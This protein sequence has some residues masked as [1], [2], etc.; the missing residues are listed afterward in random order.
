L[1]TA[2]TELIFD[3]QYWHLQ[4]LQIASQ[5][6]QLPVTLHNISHV[7]KGMFRKVPFFLSFSPDFSHF[8]GSQT[9]GAAGLREECF[10]PHQLAEN[11]KTCCFVLTRTLLVQNTL[12]TG[13]PEITPKSSL[14]DRSPAAKFLAHV[15]GSRNPRKCHGGSHDRGPVAQSLRHTIKRLNKHIVKRRYP[16]IDREVIDTD[17]CG[18][19]LAKGKR[20][21]RDF[22]HA[23]GDRN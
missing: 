1:P 8:A 10:S 18:K 16:P 23:S 15:V 22:F 5:N 14:C 13:T 17:A 20:T 3:C 2:P 11:S 6:R 7:R 19:M 21:A 9:S 4:N 12:N